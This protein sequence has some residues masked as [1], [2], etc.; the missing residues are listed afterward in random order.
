MVDGLADRLDFFRGIVGD[1]D[2]E[3]FF[4]FHHQFHGIQGIGPQIVDER[5]FAGDLVLAD[6]E[7]L[8][9]DVNHTFFD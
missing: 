8:G 4:E 3:L 1:V 7:L 9:D 6:A 5:R 2:V